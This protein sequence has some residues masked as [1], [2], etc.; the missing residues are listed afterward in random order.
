[1]EKKE[2]KK[3]LVL[4]HDSLWSSEGNKQLSGIRG[5]NRCSDRGLYM[6]CR[7]CSQ[8]TFRSSQIRVRVLHI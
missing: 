7:A 2:R 3:D 5:Y 1:M 6:K 4:A 8:K